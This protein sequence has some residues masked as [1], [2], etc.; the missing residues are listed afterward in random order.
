MST[1]TFV[2]YSTANI[3]RDEYNGWLQQLNAVMKPDGTYDA[4]LSKDVRHVWIVLLEGK[5][6]EIDMAEFRDE[7]EVLAEIRQLIGGEPRS[8][9][10]LDANN[11]R[12]SQILAVQFTALCAEHYPCV[13]YQA[14]GSA[15]FS[16]HEVLEL[17]DAG[18]GFDG[19][20]W[21]T[22]D[23]TRTFSWDGLWMWDEPED[24]L[25]DQIFTG[26]DTSEVRDKKQL[27]A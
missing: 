25:Q 17:R 1:D 13:V 21:E 5:W 23:P 14:A 12:G 18:K 20:T 22:A 4:R 16:G 10:V 9:I 15:L 3:S 24:S 6:F 27:G 8:A 11:V 19:S 7:P 2:L 26:S